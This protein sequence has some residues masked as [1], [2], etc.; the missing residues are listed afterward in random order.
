[1]DLGAGQPRAPD[2]V[3]LH[4]ARLSFVAESAD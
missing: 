1:M 2:G 3:D 4:I